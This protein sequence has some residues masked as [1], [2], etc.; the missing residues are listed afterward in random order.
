M[1]RRMNSH[2]KKLS[3]GKLVFSDFNIAGSLCRGRHP[4]LNQIHQQ[5]YSNGSE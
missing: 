5:Q 2:T 1:P 4:V 3:T